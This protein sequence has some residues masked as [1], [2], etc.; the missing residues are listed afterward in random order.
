MAALPLNVDKTCRFPTGAVPAGS[1][2]EAASAPDP[3][4]TPA[5]TEVVQSMT[6]VGLTM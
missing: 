3:S 1:H 6:D 4:S 2:A 5:M